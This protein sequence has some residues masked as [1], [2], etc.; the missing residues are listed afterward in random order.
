MKGFL[1]NCLLALILV[2]AAF[3][4]FRDYLPEGEETPA[5]RVSMPALQDS[6]PLPASP[7]RQVPAEPPIQDKERPAPLPTIPQPREP[8][9]DPDDVQAVDL[10]VT[11]TVEEQ[12]GLALKALLL[13]PHLIDRMVVTIDSLPA[14]SL[15]RKYLPVEPPK[16]GF[17]TWGEDDLL[18]IADTNSE[19]YESHVMAFTSVSPLQM[20]AL[21]RLILPLLERSYRDLGN[22]GASFE[23]RTRQ[24]IDHL[25]ASPEHTPPVWLDRPGVL[26]QFRDREMES[27]S[28]GHK[29]MTRLSVEQRR[30][31]KDSLRGFIVALDR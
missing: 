10:W 31:I 25:L 8:E 17:Q 6:T 18:R 13:T 19:R 5:P 28:I 27:M 1:L 22:P 3:W 23:I 15:N 16:G 9:V 21:Y 29:L 14:E 11:S 12:A 30:R 4:A 7:E 20:A 26:Y 2:A 24:V